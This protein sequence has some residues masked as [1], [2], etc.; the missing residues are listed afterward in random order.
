MHTIITTRQLKLNEVKNK[1]LFTTERIST[2]QARLGF[3][4]DSVLMKREAQTLLLQHQTGYLKSEAL[5]LN[6]SSKS[7]E[8]FIEVCIDN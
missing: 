8:C 4:V 5:V 7:R 3:V 2:R 1:K 6:V